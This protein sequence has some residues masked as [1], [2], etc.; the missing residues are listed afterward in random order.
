MNY[1]NNWSR[2]V[3]LPL[4]ATELALDL[5]DGPYR[6]TLA[7]SAAEPTRWEI[8]DAVVSSG[9]A[10]LQRSRE[11]TLEQNWP[12][13]SVIYNALTAGVVTDL[14][15]AMAELQDR[16]TALENA[17]AGNDLTD[18]QGQRLTDSAGNQLTTGE[19]A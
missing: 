11:G 5:P 10:T 17:S 19:I 8:I 3:I 12:T 9:T 4:G 7:D 1:V 2:P 13:G 6:L 15:Q 14:L 16:V 18:S